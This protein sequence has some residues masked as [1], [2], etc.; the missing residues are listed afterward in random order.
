MLAAIH[1]PN[2]FPWLGFFDKLKKAE[3]FIVLDQV[4]F[5][6]KEGNWTNRT[7]I[8]VQ[9]NPRWLTVPI[10]RSYHGFR[11]INEVEMNEKIHWRKKMLDTLRFNYAKAPYYQEIIPFLE[12]LI[13]Y[14]TRYLLRFNMHILEELMYALRMDFAKVRFQSKLHSQGKATDLLISLTK[15]V[16]ADTYICGGGASEYQEDEK[17]RQNG[18]KLVYQSFQ[19][20]IYKQ[21]QI[22]VFIPGLSII[23][24][25][26]NCGLA[27]TKRVIHG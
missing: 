14:Q 9:K 10:V 4:Q 20:P 12:T 19:H 25:L 27:G 23:D 5:P 16:G 18:I 2:F 3:I 26:M 13:N 17:F 1:Q 24:V 22:K 21:Q 8:L 15:A 7:M 11:L 6:K